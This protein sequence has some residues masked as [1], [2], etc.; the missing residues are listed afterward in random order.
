VSKRERL[1]RL[2]NII[3]SITVECLVTEKYPSIKPRQ[4]AYIQA[5]VLV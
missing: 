3:K 5:Q 2:Q 4:K 1:N